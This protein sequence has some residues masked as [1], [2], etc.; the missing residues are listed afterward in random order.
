AQA[1][2]A[3]TIYRDHYPE[4]GLFNATVFQGIPNLLRALRDEGVY[5]AIATAKPLH[6]AVQVLEHFGLSRFF[7]NVVGATFARKD[8]SKAS[9][10]RDALPAKYE[11]AAM[12]GDRSFDMESAK[13]IGIDAVGVTYGYG[14]REE[15]SSAGADAI[16]DSARDLYGLLLDGPAL[17]QRGFFITIEGLDKSGKTTQMNAVADHIRA[18]GYDVL[19]TREPG[20]TRVSEEIR[21][22][23]LD[24]EKEM[25]AEAESLLYA[26]ARAQ[27]VH[28]RIRPALDAGRI[29]LCDRFVDSSI[30]YQGAGRELGIAQVTTIN[31]FA[32][33]GTLPDLTLLFV[34]DAGT[35]LLRRSSATNLDRLERSGEE[36]FGRVYDAYAKLSKSSARFRCIDACRDIDCVTNDACREI[37]RLLESR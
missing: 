14:T 12:V 13:A 8:A 10:L 11:R 5:L 17:P 26:A 22:L 36:F 20:G 29:V 35:A 32:I 19:E 16:A 27:H 37:D 6:M 4:N 18:R 2:V 21:Q 33:G 34:I 7:D 25:C 9:L 30:V 1:E 3:I 24:P 28:E 23:V 15:L 31:A